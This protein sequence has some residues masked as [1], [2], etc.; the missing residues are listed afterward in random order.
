MLDEAAELAAG[1][2]LLDCAAEA[3]LPLPPLLAPLLAATE[4]V[5]G[6]G[7]RCAETRARSET[8]SERSSAAVRGARD[9]REEAMAGGLT[10]DQGEKRRRDADAPKRDDEE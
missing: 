3:V 7:T 2:A 8:R 4:V 6:V 10:Q 5:M 1:A 9:A